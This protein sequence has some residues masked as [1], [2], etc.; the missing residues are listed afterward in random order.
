MS[1]RPTFSVLAALAVISSAACSGIEG[2]PDASGRRDG[3]AVFDSGSYDGGG[4]DDAGDGGGHDAGDGGGVACAPQR[5][6]ACSCAAGAT[7]TRECL[8]DGRRFAACDCTVY[9]REIF[10]AVDGDD[11]ASGAAGAPKAT[12]G[13][14]L[15]VVR[16]LRSAGPLPAGGV[17]IWMAG[18]VYRLSAT[19][20]LGLDVSGAPGAPVVIRAQA[21]APVRITGGTSLPSA[22]FAPLSASDPLYARVDPA[23]RANVQVFD[24][25]TVGIT[26]FG[27][28]RQRG[29]STGAASSG[30]ELFVD[31]E[32]M[33]LGRWPDVDEHTAA[34]PQS[35]SGAELNVYGSVSPDVT[36][37]YVQTG[38]SDGVSTFRREGLVGGRQ[39]NLYRYAWTYMGTP[40][41]AW[42]L[43]T[44]T[45]GAPN[46]ADPSWQQYNGA[47]GSFL[48]NT[49]TA[50]AGATGE[51]RFTDPRLV[52]HGYAET[53][54]PV[55]SMSFGYLQDRPSRWTTAPDAWLHG[56]WAYYWADY[57]VPMGSLDGAHR[58]ITMSSSPEYGVAVGLPWY[59]YNLLEEVTEGGEWYVDRTR[60]RLYFYPTGPLG[61]AEVVVSRLEGPLLQFTDASHIELRG[62]V[63][64][65]SRGSLLQMTGG[66]GNRLVGVTLQNAGAEAASIAGTDQGVQYALVRNLGTSGVILEGGDR[67]SLTPGDNFIEDSDLHHVG[68]WDETYQAAIGLYGVGNRASHNHIHDLPA[69]AVVFEGNEH[70]IEL[71]D[72]HDVVRSTRD[73]AAIYTGHDWGYRGNVVRYNYVHDLH[74]IFIE[75]EGTLHAVYLDDCV[76]GERVEGNI[77]ANIADSAI[78]QNGGRDNIT[79]G[80]VIASSGG[81][82]LSLAECV[83]H[84]PNNIP[85]NPGNKLERIQAMLYQS[86]P[87][88]VR[89]PALARMP[90]DYAT[91]INP[92]L[93]WLYPEGSIFSSNLGS[94]IAD[95]AWMTDDGRSLSH[96]A[97]RQDNVLTAASPFVD[98][99]GAD[100]TL[101]A[102][103]LATPG[104]S[105]IPTDQIGI[106]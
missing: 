3:S 29:S 31:G 77:F 91:L 69:T 74:S 90:N 16:A 89:Y 37:H 101:T 102:A 48:L 76:S 71:N 1:K 64:E 86:A 15:A 18:G 6:E 61:T 82:L 49:M 50:N 58:I 93:T 88:S 24:L 47:E 83:A 46:R 85:G 73:A 62:V 41:R 27:T 23:A 26:D 32:P 51:I 11:T 44:A 4:L 34:A 75:G 97:A 59:A 10:V 33:R 52:T 5:V 80:N 99:T 66:T 20:R 106:R 103:V 2:G 14:A 68:R 13:G 55:T 87:W 45:T 25:S 79:V 57:H 95:A 94:Q 53:A 70:V 105:A 65:H 40:F 42:F 96:Y 92:A 21:G 8:P 100:P 104:L 67:R 98:G 30:M 84:P 39:Y 60:G 17:V 36:G 9:G 54:A 78:F 22:G 12:L 63:L 7:G 28:I 38:T 43:T 81:G 19:E 56:H 35:A 72:I